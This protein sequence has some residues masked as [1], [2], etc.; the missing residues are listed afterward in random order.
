MSDRYRMLYDGACPMCSREVIKLYRRRPEAIEPVDIN[1]DDFDAAAWGLDAEQVQS[2]LYGIRPDGSI[3]V[4][5][6]SLREGYRLAGLGW[7]IGWTSWWPVRPAFDLFYL[8]F[9][10][11]RMRI[12]NWLGR[13]DGHCRV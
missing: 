7:L 9:A 5:M 4:G 6:E 1:A 2:A 8:N 13:C 12:S 3:T 10:R 11:N